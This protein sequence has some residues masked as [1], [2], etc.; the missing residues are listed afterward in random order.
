MLVFGP[1]PSRRL[2]QSLGINNIPPKSCSYS[3]VYCQIGKTNRMCAKRQEFYKSDE[4]FRQTEQKINDIRKNGAKVDYLTFVPDGEPT[5]DI[6]LGQHIDR[7]KTFGI[8]IAVITNAS[9]LWMDDVREDVMKADWVSVKVDAVDYKI[10]KKIDRPHG[11]LI[12]DTILKGIASFA[13]EYTG[14]L[15]SETM[16]VDRLNDHK[17][18]IEGIAEY[19]ADILPQKSYLLVPT[20]PPAETFA[21]KPTG[22]MLRNAYDIMSRSGL[23]VE[24]VTV[25][26]DDDFYFTDD[27]A[28]DLLSI[29]SVH[30]VREEVIEKLLK[31]RKIGRL[32]IDRLI[33]KDLIRT[34][35][36]EGK[37]FYKRN[38]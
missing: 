27:I 31:K 25:D 16:L 3:C 12:L 22:E 15:V 38:L 5:L 1:V 21:V 26:E 35:T 24:C 29:S 17:A 20:R 19:L 37:R 11:T 28:N 36:Y 9:L 6:H 10:W 4:L 13:K 23:D 33:E 14:T 8:K 18:C 2:G 34:Y 32:V 30:P 7:L